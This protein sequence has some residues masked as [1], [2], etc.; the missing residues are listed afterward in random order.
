M[1]FLCS[2][3]FTREEDKAFDLMISADLGKSQLYVVSRFK[4]L[5][6]LYIDATQSNGGRSACA[7]PTPSIIAVPLYGGL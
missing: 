3:T 5:K 2:V 7:V 1:Y 4:L 6:L